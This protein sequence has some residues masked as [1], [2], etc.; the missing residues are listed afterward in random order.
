VLAFLGVG[1]AVYFVVARA[2]GNAYPGWT[3]L[4][5]LMLLIGGLITIST[6]VTGLYIGRVFNEAR[7]RPLFV[8]DEALGWEDAQAEESP[9]DA[10]LKADA[11]G[12]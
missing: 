7:E 6:G 3:S 5:V 12:R 9:A 10:P 2:S 1:A 8:I 4:V 11:T